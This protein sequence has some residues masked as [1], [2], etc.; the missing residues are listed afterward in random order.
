M[1][2]LANEEDEYSIYKEWMK[3]NYREMAFVP[4]IDQ[5]RYFNRGHKVTKSKYDVYAATLAL[6]NGDC[7]ILLHPSAEISNFEL[8]S[9]GF[10]AE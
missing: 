3:G 10:P 6:A 7:N 4:C 5:Y 2:Y 8:F 9:K 1:S